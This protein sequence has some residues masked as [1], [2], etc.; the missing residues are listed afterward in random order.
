MITD[1]P[2]SQL[3]LR[4]LGAKRTINQYKPA[5]PQSLKLIFPIHARVRLPH[6]MGDAGTEIVLACMSGAM[7]TYDQSSEGAVGRASEVIQ[8]A[9][10]RENCVGDGD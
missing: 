4:L 8:I 3:F 2:A 10:V 5:V 6:D 1:T 7:G 9:D